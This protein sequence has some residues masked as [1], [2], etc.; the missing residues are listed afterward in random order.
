MFVAFLAACSSKGPD[1]YTDD[2]P[3]KGHVVILADEG[4]RPLMERQEEVFESIYVKAE[5]D[6]RYMPA[7]ELL[8]AAG[9][10][11]P[12]SRAPR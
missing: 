5:L 12:P 10:I 7:A 8:K 2:V 1:P 3:T 9:A 11:D 6:I 4:I